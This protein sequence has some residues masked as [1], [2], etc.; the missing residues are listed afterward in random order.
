MDAPSFSNSAL[1]IVCWGAIW[2]FNNIT[3]MGESLLHTAFRGG[4]PP[5]AESQ[6]SSP[7]NCH[8]KA[9][10]MEFTLPILGLFG[11]IPSLRIA[12]SLPPRGLTVPM[13]DNVNFVL[14]KKPIENRNW[15]RLVFAQGWFS[16]EAQSIRRMVYDPKLLV[17]FYK[18]NA[19]LRKN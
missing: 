9:H 1:L 15:I 2:I 5:W 17:K 8:W 10:K 4:T 12:Y 3:G 16:P 19:F 18:T 14:L 6:T 13:Y 7:E 11:W